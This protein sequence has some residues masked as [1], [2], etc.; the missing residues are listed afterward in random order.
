MS[1]DKSTVVRIAELARL[2]VPEDELD[3]LA[4]ELDKILLWIEQLSEIDTE[5]VAPMTSVT[6]M[7]L[8]RR[9]DMVTDGGCRDDVLANAPESRDARPERPGPRTRRRPAKATPPDEV[10]RTMPCAPGN[11]PSPNGAKYS[12]K[13]K[14]S[15]RNRRHANQRRKK[16]KSMEIPT[17]MICCKRIV[18]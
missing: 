14:Q 7:T 8:P 15:L 10:P 5:G 17:K 11:E 4:G 9:D 13:R 6:E 18:I 16:H 2:H 3:K 12:K 1:V